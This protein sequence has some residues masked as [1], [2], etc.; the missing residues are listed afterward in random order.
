MT[1]F[2]NEDYDSEDTTFIEAE[3]VDCDVL[4]PIPAVDARGMVVLSML[5]AISSNRVMA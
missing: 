4:R 2:E 1:V 5:I 3:T